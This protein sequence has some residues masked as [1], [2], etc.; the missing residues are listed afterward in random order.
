MMSVAAKVQWSQCAARG[1]QEG[2]A[3]LTAFLLRQ[4]QPKAGDG[5]KN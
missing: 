3:P 4:P 5:E 1:K 2:S